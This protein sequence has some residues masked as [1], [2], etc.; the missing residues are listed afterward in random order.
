MVRHLLL[1][2]GDCLKRLRKA[3]GLGTVGMARR[4]GVSRTTLNAVEADD[5]GPSIGTC[6]RVMP[7][8]GVS[9]ERA[10][11]VGD[12]LQPSPRGRAAHGRW[13]APPDPGPAKFLAA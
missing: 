11:L 4:V 5:P 10:L 12:T 13:V 6:L 2:L 8:L 1:Q 9:G 7:V 3:Q